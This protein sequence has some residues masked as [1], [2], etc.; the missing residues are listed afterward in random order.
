MQVILFRHGPAGSNDPKRWPD[1]SLRPLTTEGRDRTKRAAQGLG[2][3]LRRPPAIVSSSFKRAKQ[4]ADILADT[5]EKG[6]VEL[7][8]ELEPGGSRKRVV[9]Q[10]AAR[11]S[12]ECVVLVGHEP[13]LG[14]LAGM[15]LTGNE[16]PLP[17]KKAGACAIHFIGRVEP[18]AGRLDWFLT[19]RILRRYGKR[20]QVSG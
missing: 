1:D 3:L 5:L 6:S 10:L 12:D 20:K 11:K 19:P 15:L 7:V 18:G 9:Q 13:D 14:L 16:L 17:L 4:T 8:K 2:K